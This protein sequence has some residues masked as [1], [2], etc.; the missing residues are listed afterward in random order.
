MLTPSLRASCL[1]LTSLS[2]LQTRSFGVQ[3]PADL[4]RPA[5][6]DVPAVST[7]TPFEGTSPLPVVEAWIEG[8]GPF[9]LLIDTGAPGSLRVGGDLAEQLG[10]HRG[11]AESDAAPTRT[12]MKLRHV[13]FAGVPTRTDL[14]PRHVNAGDAQGVIGAH[15]F[16]DV[17]LT[18]DYEERSM[19]IRT[20]P[21]RAP[22]RAKLMPLV[23]NLDE[24]PRVETR[25]GESVIP[26]E[27]ATG[28]TEDAL[29]AV[30]AGRGARLHL[31]ALALNATEFGVLEAG[32]SVLGSGA[33]AGRV[34]TL[35]QAGGLAWIREAARDARLAERSDAPDQ[36]T[37]FNEFEYPI[38]LATGRP[39]LQVSVGSRDPDAF[40]FDTGA[41]LTVLDDDYAKE[42]GLERIGTRRIGDPSSPEGTQ[43][44][45]Y[46]IEE[47]SFGD[48]LFEGM[49]AVSMDLHAVFARAG[50]TPKAIL[51][52]P[53][54]LDLVVTLDYPESVLHVTDQA[55]PMIHEGPGSTLS[56]ESRGGGLP[57]FELE[58]AGQR[59]QTH[60]DSGAPHLLSLPTSLMPELD[61]D[62]EPTLVGRARTVSGGFD[63]HSGNLRSQVRLGDIQLS[64]R[65]VLF[66]ERLREANLGGAFL[67]EYL[68][69]LDQAQRRA[70]FRPARWVGCERRARR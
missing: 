27:I 63:I 51:G 56:Y 3:D 11:D 12:S 55:L 4:L 18:L 52:L 35:D 42:L 37:L 31:G 58:I 50:P 43:S 44:P 67:R 46:L 29:L 49:P 69:T 66:M 47:L 5:V 38:E 9:L 17:V 70:W 19:T 61:L 39:W 53:T 64:N 32:H 6:V 25:L 54:F 2:L 28:R 23:S 68:V 48:V 45:E 65:G 24:L 21:Y 1:L 14:L 33:L 40:L 13:K 30:G 57:I 34:L 8:Q 62:G 60:L 7:S 36:T 41:S 59:I 26:L 10:L 16:S 20:S 22:R 15:L